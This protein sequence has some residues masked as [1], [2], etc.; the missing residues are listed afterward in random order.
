MASRSTALSRQSSYGW[1]LKSPLIAV[2]LYD[3]L[4]GGSTKNGGGGKGYFSPTN[5]SGLGFKVCWI[6]HFISLSTW[7][8]SGNP[9]KTLSNLALMYKLHLKSMHILWNIYWKK[10][11]FPS[12]LQIPFFIA[13]A[14]AQN[15]IQY[16]ILSCKK[17]WFVNFRRN[18]VI[19][20]LFYNPP[21]REVFLVI[22]VSD[23]VSIES[24]NVEE[25]N[26]TCLW[27][28]SETQVIQ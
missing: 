22:H 23:L 9:K 18:H 13:H 27:G 17:S 12:F 3:H 7:W 20:C 19:I 8:M 10:C 14:V 21:Y 26:V 6:L 15:H 16:I 25:C 2:E 4:L 24:K 5:T 11:D 1:V 28:L